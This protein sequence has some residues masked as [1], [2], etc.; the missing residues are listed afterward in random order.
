MNCMNS[1]N[2]NPVTPQAPAFKSRVVMNTQTADALNKISDKYGDEFKSNLLNQLEDIKYN[3]NDDTVELSFNAVNDQSGMHP[4]THNILGLR[5]IQNIDGDTY[6]SKPVYKELVEETHG[7]E[8]I[9]NMS[10]A[11]SFT[12]FCENL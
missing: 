7:D 12:Y 6:I 4:I 2:F 10:I 9:S 1:M 3:R 11:D 5:T 8:D